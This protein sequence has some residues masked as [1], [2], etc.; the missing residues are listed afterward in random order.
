[1]LLDV[2]FAPASD[3]PSRRSPSLTRWLIEILESN[4]NKSTFLDF[5]RFHVPR[6]S[7]HLGWGSYRE[8]FETYRLYD[9][10]FDAY[11][12]YA[13]HGVRLNLG[14]LHQRMGQPV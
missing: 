1:M 10:E 12:F 14:L 3:S 11:A 13:G 5:L 9:A 7:V 4:P 6:T 2:I 8:V